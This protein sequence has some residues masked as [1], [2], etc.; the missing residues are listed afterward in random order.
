MGR[1]TVYG[2]EIRVDEQNKCIGINL[3]YNF[4]CEHEDDTLGI[5]QSWNNTGLR[6][7]SLLSACGGF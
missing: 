5:V 7:I 4:F 6:N 3:G 2:K 1:P